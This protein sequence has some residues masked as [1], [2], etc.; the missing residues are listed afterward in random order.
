MSSKHKGAGNGAPRLFRR[1]IAYIGP[2]WKSQV[3]ALLLTVIV[4]AL[5][6]VNPWMQKIL[7]DNL[8]E[9]SSIRFLGTIILA[10]VG[11]AILRVLFT[12]VQNV[13][14]A[15]IKER[16]LLNVRSDVLDRLTSKCMAAVKAHDSGEVISTFFQDVEA[17]GNLYGDT[18]IQLVTQFFMLTAVSVAMIILEPVMA[19]ITLGLFITLA[20][21]LRHASSPVQA[22]SAAMQEALA[23]GS[24]AIGDYWKS[25]G[26]ARLLGAE[27]FIRRSV[28]GAL[29]L[30]RRARIRFVMVISLI[31]TSQTAIWIV[32]GLVLWY[33][34]LK[35]ISAQLTLGSLLAF[36][37]Y[38]GQALGPINTFLTF[39]G[40]ARASLG[41]AERVFT[42]T[43]T[44][45]EEDAASGDSLPGELNTI[46]FRDVGFSY[47][48]SPPLLSGVNI[49]LRRGE[50]TGLIGASGSG[51]TTLLALLT[52]QF[53]CTE[54][55]I[56]VDRS[57][58]VRLSRRSLREAVGV[59]QQDP[60]IFIASVFEN[61]RIARPEASSGEIIEA[62]RS[63]HALEFIL[64]LP[65]GFDTIIGEGRRA[66]SGGQRQRIAIARLILRNPRI[67]ILDEATSA[68]D[69]ETSDEILATLCRCFDDRI[70]LVV[71]HH[72]SVLGWMDRLLTVRDGTLN[73][74]GRD[75]A[76]ELAYLQNGKESTGA[77]P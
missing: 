10:L 45:T 16:I 42:L 23:A 71:S 38:M 54:G 39:T 33:G 67:V 13:V 53:D 62:A 7:I 72:R 2:T 18:L 44:G 37:N 22:A 31:S 27:T 48:A 61:I 70:M 59:V 35:V 9:G 28:A 30:V 51:K 8:T 36:W 49:E 68:L 57:P 29:D 24:T 75:T 19:V 76:F 56:L 14:F 55:E 6:V 4:T 64:E 69:Q 5:W 34:G 40:T 11:T 25:I 3:V 43:D 12:A 17:M 20:I 15:R 73:A 32:T 60:H 66:L 52:R 41:A 74:I 47:D 50:K 63:A 65:E 58:L 21:T 77:D 26:E 1:C 46:S